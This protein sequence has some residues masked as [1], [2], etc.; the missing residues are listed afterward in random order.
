MIGCGAGIILSTLSGL[1]SFAYVPKKPEQEN[2]DKDIMVIVFLR[3]GCDALNLVAPVGDQFYVDARDKRM[4]VDENGLDLKNG[5]DGFDFKLHPKAKAIKE[6]YDSKKMAIIHA[7]GLPNGTRSHFDAMS[8]IEQGMIKKQGGHEGWLTRYLRYN[9]SNSQLPAVACGH[10]LPDSFLGSNLAA[11]I[12]KPKEFNLH[13]DPRIFGILR[14]L[15]KGDNPLSTVAQTTL[16]TIKAINKKL[17]RKSNGQVD[18]YHP[19]VD[20]P[21]DWSIR[22]FSES[23]QTLAQLIKMDMGVHVANVDFGGWDTHDAQPYIFPRLVEGL[24]EALAAFYN[25]LHH[26]HKRLTVV[27]MSEFG[28]RLKSNKSNGTD[29][30][31]GGVA[32]ILGGNVKGGKMYGTWPGLAT[33]QL[34]N[35]VD[36]KVTTDYRIILSE[37]L[38]QRLNAQELDKVFPRFD[39]YKPLGFMG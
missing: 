16:K 13:T 33:E 22:G 35:N 39:D 6:I 31:H 2:E 27:V 4:R 17:P 14:N 7:C 28:R 3:G 19:E 30:G 1:Q 26:Y 34:D 8:M 9:Q 36:L 23:L 21:M 25:D 20:Y 38:K 5:L 24:S 11:S 37:V 18:D 15:Y 29:H 12:N 10:S 32:M